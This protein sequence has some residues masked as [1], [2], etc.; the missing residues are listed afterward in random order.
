MPENQKKSGQKKKEKQGKGSSRRR[1]RQGKNDTSQPRV[2]E[3]AAQGDWMRAVEE[4]K[5]EIRELKLQQPVV[6]NDVPQGRD[7]YNG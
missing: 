1:V 7:G 3:T 5:A 6:R 2:Q 4:C